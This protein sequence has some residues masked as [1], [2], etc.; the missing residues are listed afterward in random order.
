MDLR[1]LAHLQLFDVGGVLLSR[2][3]QLTALTQSLVV[4]RQPH[5]LHVHNLVVGNG[6]LGEKR[7]TLLEGLQQYTAIFAM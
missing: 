7:K 5:C 6:G 3:V 4:H 1:F 2:I